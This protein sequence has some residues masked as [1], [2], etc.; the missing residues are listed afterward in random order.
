MQSLLTIKDKD[1]FDDSPIVEAIKDC[2]AE[3]TN[4]KMELVKAAAALTDISQRKAL[5]VLET[6]TG[7]NPQ[8]HQWTFK[9]AE[10]GAKVYSI[11]APLENPLDSVSTEDNSGSSADF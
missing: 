1:T 9:I 6:Y 2:I 11:I 7:D 8:I 5:G 4:K 3:G 10:R